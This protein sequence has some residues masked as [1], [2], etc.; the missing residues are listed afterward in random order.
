MSDKIEGLHQGPPS[1]VEAAL[2]GY[3]WKQLTMLFPA[4]QQFGLHMPT[5]AFTNQSHRDQLA[6]GA[7]RLWSGPLE[8]RRSLFPDVI[9]NYIYPCAKVL[10]FSYHNLLLFFVIFFFVDSF[11]IKS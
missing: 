6:I 10:K 2:R 8:K 3:T 1:P 5:T 9:D 11:L 7:F 4:T